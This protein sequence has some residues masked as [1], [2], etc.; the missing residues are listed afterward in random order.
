MKK[1]S[2]PALVLTIIMI[3]GCDLSEEIPAIKTPAEL[4]LESFKMNLKDPNSGQV[5]NFENNILIYT[6]TNSYGARIQG[7][8]ICKDS[9]GK[10]QRD[11]EAETI[12]ILDRSNEI[13]IDRLGAINRDIA[14]IK[15][16]KPKHECNERLSFGSGNSKEIQESAFKKAAEELGFN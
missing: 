11:R 5:I 8:A 10:W 12:K 1:I 14:C 15:S 9:E 2:L 4:C 6:A 7:K 13:M 16:R 3:S